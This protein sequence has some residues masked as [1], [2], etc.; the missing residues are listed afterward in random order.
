MGNAVLPTK[1]IGCK[2]SGRVGN[3]FLPTKLMNC[4]L[5]AKKPAHPTLLTSYKNIGIFIYGSHPDGRR[6][7]R[8]QAL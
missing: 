4:K 1:L 2:Q 5:W 3:A 7:N 6:N 8:R